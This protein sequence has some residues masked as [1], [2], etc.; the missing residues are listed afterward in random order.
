[1]LSWGS[2]SRSGIRHPASGNRTRPPRPPTPL[3][4]A[5]L[6]LWRTRSRARRTSVVDVTEDGLADPRLAAALAVGTAT[7]AANAEFLAALADARVFAAITATATGVEQ[8]ASGLRA[9]SSAEL[10]VVL[11]EAPDGSRALPVFGDLAALRRWR[12]DARPVPL[13]GAQA[14]AAALDERASTV[15]LDPAGAAVVLAASEVATLA[16]GWVPVVGSNLASRR[17][18]GHFGPLALT[19]DPRLVVAL[20]KALAG[21]PLRGARLLSGPNGPVLGVV[22]RAAFDA[23]AL[24]ALAGR[25]VLRLGTALPATG[26]DLAVVPADGP[27][28]QVL[29][30]TERRSTG[31]FRRGR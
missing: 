2:R 17:T 24:T 28:E 22:P 21:E 30:S 25:V 6:P 4:N 12:L 5:G 8:T 18:T 29:A 14:C 27:G 10:A 1:M 3:G 31:R 20:R 16:A 13:S 26:L 11:L 15:L 7:P 19:A 9:E 23:A